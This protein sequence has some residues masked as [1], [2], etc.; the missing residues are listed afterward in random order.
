MFLFE[1]KLKQW[2]NDATEKVTNTLLSEFN[3]KKKL[4]SEKQEELRTI[5][6]KFK[7]MEE[8]I[9]AL[10]AQNYQFGIF[11]NKKF[12]N[13]HLDKLLE[14]RFPQLPKET[15]T[16]SYTSITGHSLGDSFSKFLKQ[17]S[18]H[19]IFSS[20]IEKLETNFDSNVVE[21]ESGNKST[22]KPNQTLK[23][24]ITSNQTNNVSNSLS[25]KRVTFSI[26]FREYTPCFC[27]SSIKCH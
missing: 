23:L 22:N 6:K 1:K 8:F 16:E 24:I 27:N 7:N 3:E 14:I 5:N 18:N 10:M 19:D 2:I 4:F 21:D 9:N 25:E 20:F 11:L 17:E 12:I 15:F 13:E 26:Q